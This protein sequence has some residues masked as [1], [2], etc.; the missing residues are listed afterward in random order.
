[1]ASDDKNLANLD[2][3]GLR[4]E[5]DEIDQA[6]QSLIIRRTKVVQAVG[7]YKD[8]VI[9]AGGKVKVPYRPAREARIMRTL[10]N[11]HDG[12]FPKSA[13]IQIWREMIAAGTRLE[14]PYTVAL[15]RN[16]DGQDCWELARL[17]FGCL[18]EIIEF[19]T[20]REAFGALED[21]RAAVGVF[22]KP[23]FGEA[24]PWWTLLT[25]DT[26]VKVVSKLPFGGRPVGRGEQ[27]EG[28]VLAAIDLEDSGD[29][30]TLFV[31]SLSKEISMDTVRKK[32]ADGIDGATILGFSDDTVADRRFVLVD[33]PGFFCNRADAFEATLA[34]Q[35]LAPES[36]RVVGAYAVP[37]SEDA[38]S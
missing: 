18:N 25:D 8:R 6:L 1:M 14:A 32:I 33:V 22:P 7:A 20:P 19:D 2:L 29:D 15:C 11:R 36:L 17:N 13:L 28:F 30:R 34:K 10:V 27:T 5:I 21:G 3:D 26:A 31:V 12:A 4:G 24:M 16:A 37:I 23:E 38:L 35:G 9:A